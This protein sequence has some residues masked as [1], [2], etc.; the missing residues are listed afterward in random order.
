MT[1]DIYATTAIP[2]CIEVCRAAA[3]ASHSAAGLV[4]SVWKVA[5]KDAA[6]LSEVPRLL[7]TSEA[8]ARAATATLTGMMALARTT[9]PPVGTVRKAATFPSVPPVGTACNAATPVVEPLSSATGEAAA[10]PPGSSLAA[11]R[12]KKKRSHDDDASPQTAQPR[13][14]DVDPVVATPSL[15]PPAPGT[16]A[17]AASSL[18]TAGLGTP[19]RTFSTGSTVV[20][21]SDGCQ[22]GLSGTVL[23]T[24]QAGFASVLLEESQETL[25]VA[26]QDLARVSDVLEMCNLRG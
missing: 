17:L 7:R 25:R 4:T 8:L 22:F 2:S 16:A 14:M 19:P 10:H 13:K 12:R 1:I 3:L 21:L 11:R 15:S 6:T 20:V 23:G 26:T 18:A 5:G 24:C 9:V